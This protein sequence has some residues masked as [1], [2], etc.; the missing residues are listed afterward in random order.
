MRYLIPALLL[1]LVLAGCIKRHNDPRPVGDN[2]FSKA[3]GFKKGCYWVYQLYRIDTT[4]KEI[5]YTTVTDS[6]YVEKD[7]TIDGKVYF[8]YVEPNTTH[9]WRDS[10]DNIVSNEGEVIFSNNNFTD[11]FVQK[12]YTDNVMMYRK[13]T[14]RDL[15]VGAPVDS[16]ETKTMQTIFY[17]TPAAGGYYA[18]K[19][20][21]MNVRFANQSGII[22]QTIQL[23]DYYDYERRLVRYNAMMVFP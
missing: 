8:K 9:Y 3:M 4:G 22:I 6:C 1:Q 17:H 10:L 18:G 20:R 16:F 5:M 13:M 11:T 7:T 2:S 23:G 19:N 21:Y 12:P 15:R 14:D